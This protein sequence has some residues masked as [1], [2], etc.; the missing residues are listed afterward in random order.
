MKTGNAIMASFFWFMAI[1]VPLGIIY[2]IQQFPQLVQYL[3][4]GFDS[5]TLAIVI[6]FVLTA[7]G[8]VAM[9]FGIERRKKVEKYQEKEELRPTPTDIGQPKTQTKFKE[10]KEITLEDIEEALDP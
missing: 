2:M 1:T 7:L 9:V 8:V 5:I 4:F 3:P 10:E 6:F